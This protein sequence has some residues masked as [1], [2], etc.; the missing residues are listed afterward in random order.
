MARAY[1]GILGALAFL[2][3]LIRGLFLDLPTNHVLISGL[4]VFLIFSLT[5]FCIGY[6]ADQSMEESEESRFK[7]EMSGLQ[8]AVASKTFPSQDKTT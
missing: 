3:V 7:G 2:L 4:V 6:V 5:G 1:S 8:V